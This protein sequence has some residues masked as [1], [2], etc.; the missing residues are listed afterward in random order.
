MNINSLLLKIQDGNDLTENEAASI[1]EVLFGGTC[2]EVTAAA[3]IKALAEK[4]ESTSEITGFAMVM[5]EKSVHILCDTSRTIDTCGTGGSGLQRFNTS[6]FA[7][8]LLATLGVPVAKHGNRAAGGRCG[9]F[10]VLEALGLP[11]GLGPK[12]VEKT[13]QK[14]NLGFLFAP[15]FHPAMKFV[16]EIRKKLGIRTIFNLLGPLSNPG[17]LKRQ[18]IGVPT[19]AIAEKLVQVLKN[20]GFEHA[21]VV[22]GEDSLDEVT[23]TGKT[24]VYELKNNEISSFV[25]DPVKLG[26]EKVSFE[27]ISGGTAEENAK[28][29]MALLE[30]RENGARKNLVC[31]NAA[32]GLLIAGQS[33]SIKEG[34]LKAKEALENGKALQTFRNYK[35][36]VSSL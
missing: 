10:D 3:I 26:I 15:L 11:V 8:F 9:S 7:A 34:F 13:L 27:E 25:F 36:F 2:E 35:S 16:A 21:L 24:I 23:V 17:L 6:T 12:K 20:L 18:I 4:E 33:S 28:I 31:I 19:K 5:R 29:F 32:F 1:A 14:T 30:G 22:A